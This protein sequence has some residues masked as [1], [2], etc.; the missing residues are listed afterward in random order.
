MKLFIARS[1]VM[2]AASSALSANAALQDL[3]NGII[4]DSSQGLDWLQD[5][6]LSA[7][8]SFGVSGINAD[9]TMTW[10]TAERWIA[11]MNAADYLGY[12]DW[13]LPDTAPVN[14]NSFDIGFSYV[15]ATDRGYNIGAPGTTYAGSHAS[16]M[17]Y[18]YYDELNNPELCDVTG[19]RTFEL[20][21]ILTGPFKNVQ[22]TYWSSTLDQSYLNYPFAFIVGAGGIPYGE[23]EISAP[24]ALF[25]AW[26]VRDAAAVAAIPEP[27]SGSLLLAGLALVAWTLERRRRGNAST[28]D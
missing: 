5:A 21:P 8:S 26:A 9:G 24:T 19:C 28:A 16:E 13:R 27:A 4:Y 25:S 1:L 6:N 14:G 3:G 20:P 15:G 7:S 12:S 2:I 11:A 23:Q 22:S 10:A 17:S 18:L